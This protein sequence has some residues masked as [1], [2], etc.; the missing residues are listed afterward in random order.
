VEEDHWEDDRYGR[1]VS[2]ISHPL[3]MANSPVALTAYVYRMCLEYARL[4][5]DDRDSM[6]YKM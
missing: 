4:W 1:L 3:I 5:A 6:A 2:D